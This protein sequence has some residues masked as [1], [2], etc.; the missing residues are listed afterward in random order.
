MFPTTPLRF[1]TR[2]LPGI[3]QN[4]QWCL[5]CWC[6]PVLPFLPV[7]LGLRST[8][9]Q[10]RT[11]APTQEKLANHGAHSSLALCWFESCFLVCY[12][13]TW[14]SVKPWTLQDMHCVQWRLKNLCNITGI[15]ASKLQGFQEHVFLLGGSKQNG[16]LS[17]A[18]CWGTFRWYSE[19]L[20]K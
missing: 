6:I 7:L 11:V 19:V 17:V 16:F 2:N 18:L 9:R 10:L 13:Q 5:H 4:W 8:W 20:Q 1:I 12:E 15:A 14:S 3:K